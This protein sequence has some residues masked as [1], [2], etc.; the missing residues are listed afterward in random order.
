MGDGQIAVRRNNLENLKNISANVVFDEPM[1]AHT[2]FRI[3]GNADAFAAVESVDEI[4]ALIN[5]CREKNIP[6]MIM[7]NGS[8][9]LV[10]DKGI[11]GLV[12]QIG[13]NMSDCRIEGESVYAEAGIMMSTL[14][15]KIL[16]A[17]LSG[18]ETLSGIPGTLGGGIYMNAGAYG[19]EIKDVIE[20]VTFIDGDGE[21]KTLKNSELDFSYRH[22]MFETGKYVI[23]SCK[24]KLKKGNYDEISAAMKDYNT[25]RSDKQPLSMPSAGSTF[26]RPEGYFA[27]KLIEDCGLKGFSIGGAQVSEKH[28]GFL[29]NKGGAT[30]KDV[31]D[32]IA[33]VQKTVKEKFGVD[34][35]PEIR[36]TGEQ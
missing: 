1:S 25:R 29:V 23:L 36:L 2:T 14:A 4:K 17:E 12:I 7:G 30:A 8:N 32:L 27:G 24:I 26:K 16:K 5:Y 22:S 20:S 28:S 13:K 11:R 18:F 21:I 34:L 15:N 19:G 9:M 31:L 10:G 35:E 3:G 6:Y 33:Y